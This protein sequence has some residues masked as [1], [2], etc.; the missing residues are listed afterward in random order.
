MSMNN[1]RYLY[2][3][4]RHVRNQELREIKS[5]NCDNER[6]ADEVENTLQHEYSLLPALFKGRLYSHAYVKTREN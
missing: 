6:W 1:T 3:L 5:F 4:Y 2:F